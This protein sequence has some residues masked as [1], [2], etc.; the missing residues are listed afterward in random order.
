MTDEPSTGFPLAAFLGM[1]TEQ[2]EQGRATARVEAGPA[3]LNPH[4]SV[5]GAVLF[6][7]VDTSMGAATMSVLDPGLLCAS[8]DVELRFCRPT[9]GG[10]LSA[11]AEVVQAGKRVV[12]LRADVRD[13]DERLVAFGTGSFAVIR[14]GA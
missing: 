2:A 3:H 9:F 11:T 6:A 14:P 7:L 13:D 5:H 12:H 4:G 10:G 8:I 1:A